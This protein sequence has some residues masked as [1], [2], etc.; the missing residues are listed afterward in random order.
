M[1][2][3]LARRDSEAMAHTLDRSDGRCRRC[4]LHRRAAWRERRPDE[5]NT[6]IDD[7]I[8]PG[9]ATNYT[10]LPVVL[11]SPDVP[12]ELYFFP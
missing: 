3:T 9:S 4:E 12:P 2:A 7:P 1:S 6:S 11:R 10:D 5:R 8:H